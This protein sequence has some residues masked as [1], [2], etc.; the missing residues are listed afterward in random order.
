MK[1]RIWPAILALAMLMSLLPAQAL[2]AKL[3]F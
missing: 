3:V 1:R 2:A